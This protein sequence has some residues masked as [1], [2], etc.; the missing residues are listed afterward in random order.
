MRVRRAGPRP[1]ISG[2]EPENEMRVRR[3]RPRPEILGGEPENEN[4][5]SLPPLRLPPP[6]RAATR[7]QSRRPHTSR[8]DPATAPSYRVS[9]NP[10]PPERSVCDGSEPIDSG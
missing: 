4:E 8:R 9:R 5:G 6:H 1:E 2:F 10:P 3:A 7:P